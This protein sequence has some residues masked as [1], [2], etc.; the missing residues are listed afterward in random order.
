MRLATT[1]AIAAGSLALFAGCGSSDDKGSPI[2]AATRAELNKQLSSIESRFDAGDGACADIAENQTSVEAT[3][4]SI[5]TDVNQQVRDSLRR[6]FDRLF[7]LTATQCDEKKG[8]ETETATETTPAPTPTQTTPTQTTPT[9]TE[10]AP[11]EKPKKDKP[12][13]DNAPQGNGGG[14]AAPQSG[15]GGGAV[16]P[17]TP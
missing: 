5:P 10:Q 8:Q 17:G 4:D 7:E 9:Q 1:A 11:K 13:N 16:A 14:N 12:K 3:L 6:G 15:S 2:P